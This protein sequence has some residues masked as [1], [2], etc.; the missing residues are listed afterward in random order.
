MGRLKFQIP[1]EQHRE[2]CIVGILPHIH[3]PMTHQKVTS[4]PEAL[5][6]VMKL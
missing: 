4:H 3:C 1:N 5:E 2:W 6:I